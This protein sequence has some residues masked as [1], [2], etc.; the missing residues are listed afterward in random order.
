MPNAVILCLFSSFT[1]SHTFPTQKPAVISEH[2]WIPSLYL[3]YTIT[4]S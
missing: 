3:F 4:P 1:G 2:N